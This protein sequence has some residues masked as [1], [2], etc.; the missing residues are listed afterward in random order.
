M[1]YIKKLL[2]LLLVIL[3]LPIVSCEKDEDPVAPIPDQ[4]EHTLICYFNGNQLGTYFYQNIDMIKAALR[5]LSLADSQ[6][7]Q[8]VRVVYLFQEYNQDIITLYELEFGNGVCESKNLHTYN[9]PER[10]DSNTITYLLNEAISH[11]PAKSYGLVMGGHSRGWIPIDTDA[12]VS[13]ASMHQTLQTIADH[14]MWVREEGALMTRFF[15]DPP[16]TSNTHFSCIEIP[17]LAKGIEDTGIKFEYTIYDACFMANIESLYPLR[18]TSKYAIGSVSEIM[19]AGFPYSDVIPCLLGYEGKSFDL[20]G[21]CQAFSTYYDKKHGYSGSI[22]LIDMRELEALAAAFKQLRTSG[23]I[24]DV[25]ISAFQRYDSLSEPLFIDMGDYVK[26]VAN[27]P[28]DKDAFINQLNKTIPHKYT[29]SEYYSAWGTAGRYMID[30][31][32]YHGLTT[33]YPSAAYRDAYYQTE[34]YKATTPDAQ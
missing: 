10:L 26:L 34:W 24:D 25:T 7:Q 23:L 18:N 17:D 22:S 12:I 29:L 15:G 21:V 11:A 13:E 19:G 4:P 3:F 32:S 31:N 1:S 5:T 27:D 16:K 14:K 28:D 2:P 6:L 20:D 30:I 33:S 8:K 9:L